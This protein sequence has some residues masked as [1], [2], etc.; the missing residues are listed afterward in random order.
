MLQL[1]E[2]TIWKISPET[3]S[4]FAALTTASKSSRG[5][6]GVN[7][8]S[9]TSLGEREQLDARAAQLFDGAVE[10]RV[11]FVE[12]GMRVG[13]EE[14]DDDVEPL[15]D[16]IEDDDVV[17][18]EQPRVGDAAVVRMRVGDALAP[19]GHAVAE[20]ADRAAEKRRQR[21][22][23]DRRAADAARRSE[24]ATGSGVFSI[25]T[26]TAPRFES[27]EGVAAD[28]FAALDALEK[29]RLAIARK[30]GECSDGRDGVGAQL[31]HDGNDVVVVTKVIQIH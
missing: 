12:R 17:E 5:M 15:L 31:A 6:F 27:D 19:A 11:G 1:C 25:E 21:A 30:R 16:V 9:R 18:E 20:E 4:S 3:I 14:I 2:R 24:R 13:R 10:P 26:Q 22:L 7:S 29:K 23:R 28:V 8:A